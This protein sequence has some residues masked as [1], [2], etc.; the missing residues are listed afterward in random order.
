MR[1]G[2]LLESA[3]AMETW[4][5]AAALTSA[6]QWHY[7]AAKK[8]GTIV[9]CGVLAGERMEEHKQEEQAKLTPKDL[10]NIQ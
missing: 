8:D 3:P 6:T 9:E 4:S 5:A 7:L 1:K 2:L 10:K